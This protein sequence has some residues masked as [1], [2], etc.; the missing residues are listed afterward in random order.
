MP[1]GMNENQARALAQ[2]IEAED[3]RVKAIAQR[4]ASEN[5]WHVSKTWEVVATLPCRNLRKRFFRPK[6]WASLKP[7][8]NELEEVQ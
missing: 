8:W 6:E 4:C 3:T 7:T 5:K 1:T 2:Q